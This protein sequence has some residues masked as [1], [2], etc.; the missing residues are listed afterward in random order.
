[1][2]DPIGYS[3]MALLPFWGHRY[4]DRVPVA[5]EIDHL[6]NR[7]AAALD[8]RAFTTYAVLILRK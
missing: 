2:L 5:R 3:E 7:A 6:A 8:I 1:M 4:L